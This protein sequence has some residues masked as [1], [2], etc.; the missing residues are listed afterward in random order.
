M[1]RQFLLSLRITWQNFFAAKMRTSLTVLG[2]VIGIA[3]VLI[4]MSVGASAQDLILAQIRAVGSNLIGVLPGASE[5]DGPPA[6][7]MGIVVTTLTN[8]D[9]EAMQVKSN[10]P[11][12]EAISG[13]VTGSAMVTHK[14]YDHAHTFQGVSADMINV[15]NNTIAQGRFFTV[16]EDEKSAHVAVIGS[17]VA[18][19]VF[20]QAQPIGKKIKI[21]DQTFRVIGVLKP[22]GSS[23]V[24][25]FDEMIYIPL[26]TAQQNLL[27]ID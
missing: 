18:E 16:A 7:A 26:H 11:H 8:D 9:L 6:S 14:D 22:K 17:T 25:N 4:V 1:I 24:S 12:V 19:D 20:D 10:A 2:I 3:A 27:G 13:Y 15:E 21:A 23:L 5:E